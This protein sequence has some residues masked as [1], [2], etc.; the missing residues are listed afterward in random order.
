MRS[1]RGDENGGNERASGARA[2]VEADAAAAGRANHLRQGRCVPSPS[3]SRFGRVQWVNLD[4]L[5][6]A[7]VCCTREL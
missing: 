5:P 1:P 6:A 3:P 2:T 7:A 4:S